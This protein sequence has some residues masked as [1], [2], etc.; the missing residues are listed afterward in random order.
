ML[1]QLR[2]AIVVLQAAYIVPVDGTW[3]MVSDSFSF[4]SI[5]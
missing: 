4:V 1:V 5:S 3:A 2:V